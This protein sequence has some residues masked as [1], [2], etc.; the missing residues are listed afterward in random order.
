MTIRIVRHLASTL[1]LLAI[2]LASL[3][4]GEGTTTTVPANTPAPKTTP[5]GKPAPPPTAAPA[6]PAANK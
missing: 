3:G 5:D 4:C 1:A 6:G 2:S